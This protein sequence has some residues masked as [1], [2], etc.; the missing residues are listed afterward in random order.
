[1]RMKKY[2]FDIKKIICAVALAM[3]FAM[4]GASYAYDDD[5]D[6]Y[7]SYFSPAFALCSV[8]AYNVGLPANPTDSEQIS[9][10]NEVISYKATVIAQ[11]M[12]R[13]YDNLNTIIKRFKT[14][15][16]KAVL[17]SKIEVMTGGAS[18]SSSSSSGSSAGN[19]SGIAD[20]EDCYTVSEANVYDCLKRN[21]DK[22]DRAV[23]KDTVNAR[24]QLVTDYN[25]AIA[26]QTDKTKVDEASDCAKFKERDSYT[27]KN[28]V[29]NCVKWLR[30]RVNK[31]KTEYEREN[32]RSR[33][34]SDYD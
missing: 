24:K 12:K 29:K 9:E 5:D 23:E 19:N 1:M 30:V 18:S 22:I 31:L 32:S 33:Y 3:V 26:Y 21:L 14:Q 7:C 34:R 6:D 25:I 20:A 28:D 11:Q 8:H 2:I 27:N 13:Q 4:P 16:E 15:L 10:M 17:T